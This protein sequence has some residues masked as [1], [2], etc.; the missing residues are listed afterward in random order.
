[1]ALVKCSE[2]QNS[3]SDQADSCP[4]CGCPVATSTSN[5]NNY[6]DTDNVKCPFCQTTIDIN[7][8]V[9]RG[10][11][12]KHGYIYDK[13]YGVIGKTGS[14]I[15]LVIIIPIVLVGLGLIAGADEAA[16]R[17]M[18]LILF[19]IPIFA[20]VKTA[21]KLKNGPYWYKSK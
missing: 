4:K 15:T 20:A 7:A 3:I 19:G 10:C 18:Y 6:S 12:A 1:M 14:I 21:W 16:V 17:F 2:C 8:T 11:D 9:C 13:R 5:S